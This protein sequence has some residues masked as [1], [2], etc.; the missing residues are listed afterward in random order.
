MI[1]GGAEGWLGIVNFTAHVRVLRTLAWEKECGPRCVGGSGG[2]FAGF[3]EFRDGF[4]MIG[5]NDG[6]AMGE[7]AAS[8][9]QRVGNIGEVGLF[10]FEMIRETLRHRIECGLRFC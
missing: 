10:L 9:G 8:G 5:C 3:A 7:R 2:G 6:A 1:D 4:R